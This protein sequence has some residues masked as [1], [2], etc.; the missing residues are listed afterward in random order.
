M[1]GYLYYVFIVYNDYIDLHLLVMIML[2]RSINESVIF[3][4]LCL[5]FHLQCSILNSASDSF[6]K[7]FAYKTMYPG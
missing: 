6:V 1:Q 2:G 4:V 7:W 5:D 3:T